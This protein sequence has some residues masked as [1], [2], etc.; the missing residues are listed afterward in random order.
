M[1]KK[2]SGKIDGIVA[3][4]TGMAR[5]LVGDQSGISSYED[6]NFIDSPVLEPVNA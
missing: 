1:K 5:A 2:S 6:G 4:I 3:T